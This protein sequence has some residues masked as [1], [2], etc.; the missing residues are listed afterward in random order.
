LA[1]KSNQFFSDGIRRGEAK[2]ISERC[3]RNSLGVAL[4]VRK[5]LMQN[6]SNFNFK[7]CPPR[8]IFRLLFCIKA[9]KAKR[10]HEFLK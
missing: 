6:L 8:R 5:K 2:A 1:N 3:L 7:P 9:N 4:M 10:S